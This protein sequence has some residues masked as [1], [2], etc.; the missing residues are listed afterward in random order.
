MASDRRRSDHDDP[1]ADE[2]RVARLDPLVGSVLDG[3]YQIDFRIAAGGFGAIYHA[4]HVETGE[5]YALKVLHTELAT[6]DARVIAR[7]RREGATL[8]QLR[9]PHT[10]TA[11]ELGED[12]AGPLYIVMELLHGESLYEV[13]RA[14][15]PLPW[16]RMVAIARMVCSSLG[17]AHALG[18]IHRDLKPANIHLERRDGTPDFVKVLDFGI[19]KILRE[20][21]LD[22]TELTQAGQMIGTFDYMAPEQMVGG[23][24]TP[25]TDIY[26]LGI[27]MFEMIAGRRPFDEAKSPTSMLAAVLTQTAPP[28]STYARVPRELERIV[29]RCLEREPQSRY[30]QVEELATDLERL[31]ANEEDATR[32]LRAAPPTLLADEETMIVDG[33]SR[34]VRRDST[35]H[36]IR[37]APSPPVAPQVSNPRP[38][39][40]GSEPRTEQGHMPPR[41]SAVPRRDSTPHV[42]R[43]DPASRTPQPTLVDDAGL[44]EQTSAATQIRRD[45]SGPVAMRAPEPTPTGPQQAVYE[46]AVEPTPTALQVRAPDPTFPTSGPAYLGAPQTPPQPTPGPHHPAVPYPSP[47][48]PP[49]QATPPQNAQPPWPHPTPARGTPVYDM[50]SAR[51]RELVVR[52]VVWAIAFLL[53]VILVAVIASQV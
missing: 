31:V 26:T 32:Q 23:E 42:I 40:D 4:T 51:D 39:R 37:R 43:R 22:Q 18:I 44:D 20:S 33:G 36:V 47:H 24:C 29:A 9:D 6:S 27:V 17:E 25:S 49:W 5:Q 38:R 11:Y 34:G 8:A 14:H 10:I 52:R 3:R 19:A 50:A 35:P 41:S 53:G 7:F 21:E 16:Q 30:P 15:G 48:L 28:L 1:L 46:R 2:T 45:A 13:Y 12:P